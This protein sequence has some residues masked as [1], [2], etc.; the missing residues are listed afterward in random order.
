MYI[1][2]FMLHGQTQCF[3]GLLGTKQNI[4]NLLSYTVPDLVLVL[5]HLS[6]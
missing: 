6:K 3:Q 5:I 2:N 1:F 4:L